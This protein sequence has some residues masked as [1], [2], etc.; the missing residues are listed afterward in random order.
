MA[1]LGSA[2]ADGSWRVREMA[3]TV[4][5]RHLLGDHL[6]TVVGLRDDPAAR[7]RAVAVDAV[8]R[9]TTSGA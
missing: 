4:V 9:L 8:E 7:V 1:A 2:L 6:R 5:R 3:V